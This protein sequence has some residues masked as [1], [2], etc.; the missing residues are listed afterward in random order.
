MQPALA[1]E[2]EPDKE[3]RAEKPESPVA[4]SVTQTIQGE[5]GISVQ[6]MCTNC[7]SADLSLGS[8]GNEFL[9]VVCDGLPVPAGLAQIYL[10]SVLPPW[11][12]D[13]VAVEKGAGRAH[14]EGG[15][16]GGEIDVRRRTPADGF[17]LNAGADVGEFGWHGSR[18]AVAGRAGWFGGS[19]A[20]SWAES[21][22]VDADDDGNP[23]M[24]SIDR[25]TY[26]GRIDLRPGKRHRIALGTIGYDESQADGR[27]AYDLW[28][29]TD[30]E[31]EVWDRERVEIDREQYDLTYRLD[32]KDG[33]NLTAGALYA[34]RATLIEEEQGA[35]SGIYQS[36]YDIGEEQRHA[37]LSWFRPLGSRV[38]LRLGASRTE[39]EFAVLDRSFNTL[40]W[41]PPDFLLEESPS[42]SGAWLEGEF[43]L[44][45]GVRLFA[46]LRYV[47]FE[48]TDNMEEVVEAA[49]GVSPEWLEY[50]LPEGS[51]WLP[52]VA[53]TWK[54]ISP[55][56]LRFSYGEGFRQAPA[57]HESVCCGR[58]FRGNRGIVMEES[59]VFGLEAT[60]QPLPAL[61]F[62]ASAFHTDFDN[63]VVNMATYS[64]SLVPTYQNVNVPEAC[65]DSF[66]LEL[67]WGAASWADIRA[68][69]TRT[70]ADNRT[71][72][73]LIPVLYD[74]F[75]FPFLWEIVS[76]DIPYI[77]EE[78]GSL[79]L[80]LR[81]DRWGMSL[82]LSMQYAGSMTIQRFVYP[83]DQPLFTST[84][85]FRV[86]NIR[87]SKAFKRGFD[88]FVGADNLGDYVQAD[89]ADP[90]TDYT[91]GPLRGT[92]VYGG[93]TYNFATKRR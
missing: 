24:A 89:L 70:D 48:Y 44:G 46:G 12:I 90:T 40:Q 60:Y 71:P 23:D 72:G 53:L 18:A 3:S 27:G 30:L 49:F 61:Q 77:P 15:A 56:D 14:F 54:P 85:S 67:R 17:Q 41:L 50:D 4:T 66:G 78:A 25:T 79:G 76:P 65:Y 81:H 16:V 59:T 58:R 26:E 86:Y 1:G 6:T 9:S 93:V 63:L 84:P 64:E 37:R 74:D 36:T 57:T 83:D 5:E 91:W 51:D 33:S 68:S 31:M 29:S 2:D 7:N 43:S 35:T 11:C 21:D 10:L 69:F 13:N 22:F 62:I 47:D 55:L 92:Y 82:D 73:D 80:L 88:L 8:F 28:A 45:G 75:G 38:V 52:R 20:G 87:A 32:F 42:E 19:L 34:D 39:Q